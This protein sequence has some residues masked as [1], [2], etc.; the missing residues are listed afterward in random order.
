M[1]DAL[2]KLSVKGM[3]CA[4]CETILKEDLGEIIGITKV[5]AD[6]KKG[7]VEFV[8]DPKLLPDAKAAIEKNGY[9][10]V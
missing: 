1:A 6:H 4:S 10:V 3:H 2:F 7:L 9:K 8:A 5:R